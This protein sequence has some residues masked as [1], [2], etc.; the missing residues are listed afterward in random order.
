MGNA[1]WAGIEQTQGVY[2]WTQLDLFIAGNAAAGKT[3]C[4]SM[5]YI[6]SFYSQNQYVGGNQ[7]P[8]LGLHG[9]G[10]PLTTSGSPSGFTGLTNFITA[11]VAR[12]KAKGTPIKYWQTYE[13]PSYP[14]TFNLVN[15]N[16]TTNQGA[17]STTITMTNTSGIVAGM[18]AK[19][20]SGFIPGN[21][22]V[23]SVTAN[24]SIVITKT[25][26]SPILT[27][28]PL[29][30]SSATGYFWGSAS[31]LVDLAYVAYQAVKA[32]DPSIIVWGPS[33]VGPA[34]PGNWVTVAGTTY[35]AVIGAQTFDHYAVDEF[36][37]WPTNFPRGYDPL[38]PLYSGDGLLIPGITAFTAQIKANLGVNFKPLVNSSCGFSFNGQG[39][40]A[41]A[42]RAMTALQRK[43][44]VARTY[45]EYAANGYQKVLGYGGDANT[46]IAGGNSEIWFGDFVNDTT[47]VIAGINEV[48]AAIVGKTMTYLGVRADGQMYATFSDGTTY[49]V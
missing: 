17:A 46:Y 9:Y 30:F 1:D 13:E 29:Y 4:Y 36:G 10:G 37:T 20:T 41:A 32:A 28:N 12:Y 16:A 49:T 44:Y 47:G 14:V 8:S 18:F 11:L 38:Q 35:P 33:A 27:T 5:L 39:P 43:Q 48:A 45:L 25:P 24:T 3:I 34:I 31:Q 19:D 42:F 40:A 26:T 21:T 15:Q 7:T 6:P 22:T 2:N 23:V